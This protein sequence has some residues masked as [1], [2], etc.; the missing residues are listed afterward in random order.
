MKKSKQERPNIILITSDQQRADFSRAM[1]Y[2]LD[3]TPA[4]DRLGKEGVRFPRA[5]CPEPLCCPT[6]IS[7][8]T[9]RFSRAHGG[10]GNCSGNN[11]RFEKDFLDVLAESGY[12]SVL[13]GKD[14]T[15]FG[16]RPKRSCVPKPDCGPGHTPLVS[17]EF[18]RSH[19]YD[20]WYDTISNCYPPINVE[21]FDALDEYRAQVHHDI[22]HEAAPFP[23][24]VSSL[25]QTFDF[26]KRWID[27]KMR[28]EPFFMWISVEPP[29]QPYLAPEPYFSMF[30][31][32]SLPERG[33]GPED[34][35][36]M[37]P[38]FQWQLK[39]IQ[40]EEDNDYNDDWR[41]YRQ[42]YLGQTRM[43]DDQ[44]GAFVDYLK[45]S[46]EWENTL[47]VVTT[48]HGD[49]AGDY[50]LR[51]KGVGVPECLCRVPFVAAGY[52]INPHPKAKDA[53]ISLVDLMPTFCE[54]IGAEIPRGV[55]GRSLWPLLN[56]TDYEEGEFQSIFSEYGLG[57][58]PNTEK[59][60]PPH[61]GHF[62]FFNTPNGR[63][64]QDVNTYTLSGKSEMVVKG[65]WKLVLNQFYQYELYHLADDPAEIR[66]LA[67]DPALAAKLSEMKDELLYWMRAAEDP[68]PLD[69]V[70]PR[71]C[72]HNWNR[73]PK[74]GKAIF[75]TKALMD[76]RNRNQ[77]H[78]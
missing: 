1:G 63:R 53:H 17:P 15:Y 70:T 66:N 13:I 16:H 58:S 37:N 39:T 74:R 3:I 55:Q 20:E 62:L 46:G 40:A 38:Y 5:Y 11:I 24:E 75:D 19:G 9:G 22:P 35:A 76:L 30:P 26:S 51:C 7:I 42:I 59:D 43:F 31:G 77:I 21:E 25:Y 57:G 18:W 78:I 49:F 68:L 69:V 41:R 10:R 44:V 29:H 52:G 67:D 71:Q 6:R 36:G 50:G 27:R 48:D 23:L 45:Q 32:E 64:L 47:L 61:D 28:S 60:E 12:R 56:G 2:P 65:D 34:V 8:L 73:N 33:A 72:E 14:H 54:V 4:T